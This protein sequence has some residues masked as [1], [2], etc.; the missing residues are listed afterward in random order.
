MITTAGLDAELVTSCAPNAVAEVA[1]EPNLRR[2]IDGL[3]TARACGVPHDRLAEIMTHTV[4]RMYDGQVPVWW[5]MAAT[6]TARPGERWP[7]ESILIDDELQQQLG[8]IARG[9]SNILHSPLPWDNLS[10]VL[11]APGIFGYIGSLKFSE[12]EQVSAGY[13]IVILDGTGTD[14]DP[15]STFVGRNFD[16]ALAL[17]ERVAIIHADV[18]AYAEYQGIKITATARAGLKTVPRYKWVDLCGYRTGF[19]LLDFRVTAGMSLRE[20]NG[21]MAEQI[22]RGIYD[23]AHAY[24]APSASARTRTNRSNGILDFVVQVHI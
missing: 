5:A 4:R 9:W 1:S 18:M 19:N 20:A 8:D 7:L 21:P 11:A 10:T 12:I 23:L 22:R 2:P 13:N 6:Q 14:G 24:N 16:P 17:D 15:T 3:A